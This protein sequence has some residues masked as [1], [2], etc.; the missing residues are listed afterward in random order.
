MTAAPRRQGDRSRDL[1]S[2][3]ALERPMNGF[4]ECAA[5]ARNDFAPAALGLRFARAAQRGR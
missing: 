4:Q 1:I 3:Y 5:G 2:N